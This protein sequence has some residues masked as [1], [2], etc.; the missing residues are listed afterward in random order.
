MPSQLL[1]GGAHSC[2]GR[3]LLQG[4]LRAACGLQ[5]APHTPGVTQPTA[6]ALPPAPSVQCIPLPHRLCTRRRITCMMDG[7]MWTADAMCTHSQ[8][9]A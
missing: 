9:A 2:V 1:M 8:S 5:R 6:R 4:C 7:C 3:H